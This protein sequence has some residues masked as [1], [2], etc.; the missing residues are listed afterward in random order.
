VAF[1]VLWLNGTDLR[2][3]PLSER[4]RLKATLPARSPAISETLS[5]TGSGSK[6]FELM[7]AND[8]EGIVAKRLVDPYNQRVRWLKIKNL[9]YSQAEGRGDL[10]NG[11]PR[12]FRATA[13]RRVL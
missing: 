3:L 11:P 2:A 8:L 7:C 10:L 6:L 13:I 1:D 12:P 4:R 5:V 9:T